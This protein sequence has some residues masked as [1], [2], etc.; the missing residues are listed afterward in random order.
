MNRAQR[1]VDD[2]RPPGGE[3]EAPDAEQTQPPMGNPGP[4][5][6]GWLRPWMVLAAGVV[7]LVGAGVSVAVPGLF[8]TGPAGSAPSTASPDRAAAGAAGSSGAGA[9]TPRAGLDAQIAGLQA[10]LGQDPSSAQNWATLGL[11]YVQQGKNTINPMYYPKAEGALQR[12][13]SINHV[14]NYLALAGVAN[15]RAAEHRFAEALGAAQQAN[16]IAPANA[17]IYGALD[18]AYTQLGRYDEAAQAVQHML[19]LQP[20]T[21]SLTRAEYV[22]ELRGQ[23]PAATEVLNQALADASSPAD[24]AFC[25]YYLGELAFTNGD[26]AGALMQNTLGLRADPTYPALLE[27]K[28]KAEAALGQVDAAVADYAAVVANAP[29]PQYVIEAG[30]Y[31]QSLG[32]TGPAQQDYA[33]FDAENRLFEANGVQLDTDPTLFYADHGDPSRALAFAQVGIV[34]RPFVEMDDAYA[35]ALHVNH[36]DPEALGWAQQ[37]GA[38]G[39]RNALFSFHKGMIENS[40]GQSA[41]AQA[42]LTQALTINPH[43]N[44]LQAPIAQATPA[45]LRTAR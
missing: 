40:L 7:L 30:E 5:G 13:L 36:R 4:R 23:V 22:F 29:L 8:S 44:P 9:G 27:G 18:D 33:L 14:D 42:D 34:I 19:D 17:T 45:G 15:L 32:R 38:T 2:Q 11:D 39:M 12:S 3:P 26:P 6:R 24:Q 20:G 10:Q 41:A 35:W 31:L 21:P 28:A 25:R 1:P 43:F 37:A 16:A